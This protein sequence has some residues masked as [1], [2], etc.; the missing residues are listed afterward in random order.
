MGHCWEESGSIFFVI[1]IGYS[2]TLTRLPLGLYWVEQSQP[3]QPFFPCQ[4]LQSGSDLSLFIPVCPCF[5]W[6]GEPKLDT[7]FWMG[8][9]SSQRGRITF[10]DL[11][12]VF[13]L[14]QPR[15]LLVAFA[16]GAHCCHGQFVQQDP[17]LCSAKLLP[18]LLSPTCPGP[19]RC[20]FSN[21]RL[22]IFLYWIYEVL[23]CPFLQ[24]S[25]I[26]GMAPQAPGLVTAPGFISSAGW[27]GALW[28]II[29]VTNGDFKHLNNQLFT[30][31]GRSAQLI[32]C[33]T[34]CSTLFFSP[35]FISF[36]LSWF[37]T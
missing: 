5:C 29:Q 17:R 13:F 30:Q 26:H 18:R 11:L 20:F 3:S 21:V 19:K 6:M 25:E 28:F 14:T 8:L 22:Y 9:S 34:G 2:H 10:L 37:W 15:V 12:A 4:I 23:V 36:T 27:G 31:W 33:I 7:A 35:M 24:P 1:S 32:F 16:A